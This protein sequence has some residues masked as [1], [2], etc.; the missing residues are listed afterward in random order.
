[1]EITLLLRKWE[2]GQP[3]ALDELMPLVY[4]QLR[5][6]AAA[7]IRR[8]RQPDIFQATMLVN[9]LYLRLVN[10]RKA[11]WEDRRHF[12]AFAARAMRMI[13]IDNAR[14][15]QATMHGG[16]ATHIAL[17][18]D[19]VWVGIGSP[20]MLDLN[21]ALEELEVLDATKVRA[22]ELR[23]FLGCTSEE[24]ATLMQVSKATV[25][26]DLRFARTWLFERMFPGE[27]DTD[28]H[29]V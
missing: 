28:P 22:I 11:G 12:Y 20:D 19:L 25:D 7:Y 1:V 29:A 23:Y 5:E 4:P 24:T 26:R 13:L 15:N 9:E 16:G 10:Q 18:E 27:D 6:V 8:E 2:T 21:R 17:N 14:S 3:G